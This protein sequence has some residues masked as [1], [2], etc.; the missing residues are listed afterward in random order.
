METNRAKLLSVAAKCYADSNE[1]AYD[2][3][4]LLEKAVRKTK[5]LRDTLTEPLI[6]AAVMGEIRAICR[7]NRK[8]VWETPDHRVEDDSQG[9]Q[10]LAEDKFDDLKES[11][12]L[13]IAGLPKLGEATRDQLVHARAYYGG[14]KTAAGWRER[15][16]G[17]ILR[18]NNADIPAEDITVERLRELEAKTETG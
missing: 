10:A 9:V 15:W 18:E 17:A 5:A 3:A 6:S 8:R 14:Q 13:P 11:W 1:D 16:L 4:V 7:M 12:T 2:A